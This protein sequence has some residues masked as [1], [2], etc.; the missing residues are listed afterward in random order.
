MNGRPRPPTQIVLLRGVNIGSHN[1]I[2]MPKLR[3]ALGAAGFD[4]ARTY[5][6]SGNVALSSG[7]TPAKLATRCRQLIADAFGLDLEVIVRT[8]AELAAVVRR[9]P[10]G[11]VAT[12]PKRYQVTFLAAT[13]EPD[14]VKRLAALAA[15]PERL[16]DHG[17]ELYTWH[18]AGIARSKL[19]AGIAS[20]QLGVAAT[21]RNW[22]T[23][24]ALL[25]LANE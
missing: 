19:W 9:N 1:R 13:P 25:Q 15:T 17:R 6:Q 24:T 8:R 23:V 12:E 14:V 2:A 5:L 16:V 18:P 21:S 20:S 4:D 11:D 10:L 22:A 7:A 3:E